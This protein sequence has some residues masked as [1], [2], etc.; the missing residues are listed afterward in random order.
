M[1]KENE[2]S[3][4]YA[5]H[6]SR[7]RSFIRTVVK[8]EFASDDLAQET[9]LRAHQSMGG[10]NEQ[11]SMAPWLMKIAYNLCLDHFRRTK[12]KVVPLE[13]EAVPCD[14][15][16]TEQIMECRQMS[17]C[18]QRQ[19]LLLPEG[20]QAVIHLYDVVGL[21]QKEIAEVLEISPENVKVRL[22]RGRK[23]LKEILQQNCT[24]ELDDRSVFVCLP[25][26]QMDPP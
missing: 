19:I 26:A 8:D 22:H 5:R 14:N 10:F 9:F 11:S 17:A 2:L 7:V 6:Y 3:E 15:P 12:K 21:T 25:R 20:Q 18:V 16:R 23:R 24:F 1:K 13:D 4:I